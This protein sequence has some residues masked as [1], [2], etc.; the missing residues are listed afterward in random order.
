M[1]T[2][3]Y[4]SPEQASGDRDLDGRTDVYSLAVVL[5]EMLAG[6]PRFTGPTAQAILAQ[7]FTESPRPVRTLRDTVPRVVDD[8]IARALSRAP[9]DRFGTAAEFGRALEGGPAGG[10]AG[11]RES[12][13]PAGTAAN[14]QL[15]APPPARLAPVVSSSWGWA[16]SSASECSSPGRALMGPPTSRGRD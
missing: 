12:R 4:M 9:A 16:S 6:Q 2:P 3:A 14:S 13:A 15:S 11:G 5:Y 8:A 1:G 10:R 7:R